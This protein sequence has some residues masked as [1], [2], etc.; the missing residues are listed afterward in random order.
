[1]TTDELETLAMQHKALPEFTPLPETCFYW[2][3]RFLHDNVRDGKL[4]RDAAKIEK[5]RAIHRYNEFKALYTESRELFKERQKC[6]RL[7]ETMM[8]DMVKESDALKAADMAFEVIGILTG[9]MV[10]VKAMREKW[11]EATT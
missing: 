2:T 10:F 4:N 5:V 6:I 8:N 3:M 1:M 9:D 11:K 7:A